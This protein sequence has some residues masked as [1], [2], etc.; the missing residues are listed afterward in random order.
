MFRAERQDG[1]YPWFAGCGESDL[2]ILLLRSEGNPG[3]RLLA[4]KA[5]GERL[6]LGGEHRLKFRTT[7]GI[8]GEA[9]NS[10]LKRH[11]SLA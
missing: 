2:T 4:R 9:L 8:G 11:H 10:L 1:E 3:C 7:A 6:R 5:L